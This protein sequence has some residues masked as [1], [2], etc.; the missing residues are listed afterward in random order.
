MAKN[1]KNWP[2]MAKIG[3]N[4]P[5]WPKIPYKGLKRAKMAKNG[6][7]SK[8]FWGVPEGPG[9]KNHRETLNYP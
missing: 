2:K 7:I 4:R 5:N 3:K 1:G 6:Q 9:V 8:N